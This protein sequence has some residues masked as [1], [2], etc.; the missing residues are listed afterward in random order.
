[1]T[2]Q[3]NDENNGQSWAVL[4][5]QIALVTCAVGAAA[6]Q[7]QRTA[8]FGVM[9][10]G[11]VFIGLQLL[12]KSRRGRESVPRWI[13]VRGLPLLGGVG[14]LLVAMFWDDQLGLTALA[15][16]A[17]LAVAG[18]VVPRIKENLWKTA[19]ILWMSLLS[20]LWL[21]T[22]Y[23]TDIP[24][25]FFAALGS[26]IALLILTRVLFNMN[27]FL[28]QT[29]H[30]LVLLL[31]GLPVANLIY[32]HFSGTPITPESF[33]N[34]YSYDKSH[35]DP[36]AFRRSCDFYRSNFMAFGKQAFEF[37]TPAR[38]LNHPE[39]AGRAFGERPGDNPPGYRP[40]PGAHA[41]LMGCPV[42]INSNGF[43]GAEIPAEKGDTY[44]IVAMG[45]STTFGMTESPTDK[46]W[47]EVLEQLIRERLKPSR[48]IRVINTGVPAYTIWDNL[49]RVTSQILPL[50]PDMIISYHGA[51]GFYMFDSGLA[52]PLGEP[53]PDFEPRPLRLAAE[54]EYRLR[55][56]LYFRRMPPRDL[57]T[58]PTGADLEK[59][60]YADAYQRL[61]Q[62]AATNHIRLALGTYN[63][64]VNKFSPPS[65]VAFYQAGESDSVAL[66]VEANLV[67]TQLLRRLAAEH[68]E[69]CLID[70]HLNLDGE[71][72]KFIDLL[73]FTEAGDRQL[74][75]N[76]FAGIRQALQDDL[77]NS[78]K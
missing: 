11:I 68:P 21:V 57:D 58:K 36:M 28:A 5:P 1:M 74:A 53:F 2:L 61:I 75:E 71:H 43:R 65:V 6:S 52:P 41:I 62:I 17:M 55:A 49:S 46:P 15:I 32:L 73:H 44:R 14:L 50:H 59:N 66:Q 7:T 39:L 72:E 3:N 22:G 12:L 20:V 76:I 34:Y 18:R 4:L 54:V 10:W 9:V 40:R 13:A 47:P 27:A 23:L 19:A 38:K 70:T 67:H 60:R 42:V 56:L 33:R 37:F 30:T 78:A 63:M 25:L 29:I 64:A 16:C 31:A 26:A 69:V 8:V 77:G 45:E 35:G 48:P 51:N 24:L